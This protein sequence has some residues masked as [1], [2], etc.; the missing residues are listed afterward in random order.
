MTC[1][2]WHGG[3]EVGYVCSTLWINGVVTTR[4]EVYGQWWVMHVNAQMEQNTLDQRIR[5]G[6]RR[7]DGGCW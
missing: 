5:E 2:W 3:G 4:S 7:A 6:R 1:G